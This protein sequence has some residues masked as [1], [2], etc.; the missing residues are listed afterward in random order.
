M[1]CG[2]WT[3]PPR[4]GTP[5]HTRFAYGAGTTH[6][7]AFRDGRFS[8]VDDLRRPDV[9]LSADPVA[10]LLVFYSRRSQ[11]PEILRGRMLAWGRRPWLALSFVKRFHQP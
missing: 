9:V 4:R 10:C 7:W 8:I 5:R 2:H 1:P 3:T 6:F 11:W